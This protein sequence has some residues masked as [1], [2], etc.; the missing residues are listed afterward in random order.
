MSSTETH[1]SEIAVAGQT[2]F[3]VRL[4]GGRIV[5]GTYLSWDATHNQAEL[6]M[7]NGTRRLTRVT[8]NE[9]IEEGDSI[10]STTQAVP[11]SA[12]EVAERFE[13]LEQ[14]T[15]MVVE[16]KSKG[17]I[18]AGS[19]GLGKS[20]TVLE[21]LK[22]AGLKQFDVEDPDTASGYI[23]HKGYSTPKS[24]YRCLYENNGKVIVFDD[25]DSVMEHA[26]S[27]NI[28]KGAL[29]SYDV[30]I[31]SWLTEKQ[32]DTLPQCFE[33]TGRVIFITNKSIADLDTAILSRC[34]FVD[35]TM[36]TDEKIERL[37]QIIKH[38][39]PDV[40]LSARKECLELISA[41]RNSVKDLNIRT[42]QKVIQI[43]SAA[44]VM[45]DWK[46]L[47]VYSITTG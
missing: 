27:V 46:R 1:I 47:A 41:N 18:I 4:K 42:L 31:I 2:K 43:R 19:P 17:V 16:D 40:D 37:T 45:T 12:F 11:V 9:I 28:L 14:L 30:R 5:V 35:L 7:E 33:F 26:T 29:D 6:L 38:I 8:S 24:L 20:H 3:K 23:V 15:D 44:N 21:R 34:L 22:L 10:L 32:D 25:L 36:T 39:R 13:F